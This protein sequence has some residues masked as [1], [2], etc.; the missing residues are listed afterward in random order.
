MMSRM[1][2][3]VLSKFYRVSQC[4][5]QEGYLKTDP[6]YKYQF[7]EVW[8]WNE[9]PFR[10]DFGGSDLGIDLVIR[11]HSGDY[12][13]VQCK[14]FDEKTSID[15]AAVDSFLSTSPVL[16]MTIINTYNNQIIN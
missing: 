2:S 5:K 3:I 10:K 16:R 1:T 8:M 12:W 15:K 7:S 11:T 4:G 13:A 6:T 14:C 9:F